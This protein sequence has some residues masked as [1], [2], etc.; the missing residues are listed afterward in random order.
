MIDFI[1]NIFGKSNSQQVQYWYDNRGNLI[2]PKSGKKLF[3]VGEEEFKTNFSQILELG[4]GASPWVYIVVDRIAELCASV[5]LVLVNQEGELIN[6]RQKSMGRVN[7]LQSLINEPQELFNCWSFKAITYRCITQYLLTGNGFIVGFPFTNESPIRYNNLIP[8]LSDETTPNQTSEAKIRDW[9]VDYFSKSY[10]APDADVMHMVRPNPT[11]DDNIGH[12]PLESLVNIWKA[13][14]YLNANEHQIH[15]NKGVNGILSTKGERPILNDERR[16]ID[17]ILNEE[18][19]SRERVAKFQY[20]PREMTYVDVS[21]SFK[22]LQADKSSDRHREII[23]AAYKYPSALLNDN[24]SLTYNNLKSLQKTAFIDAVLPVLNNY[25]NTLN[26]WLVVD[27]YGL[28]TVKIGYIE[29]DIPQLQ[30]INSDK[31]DDD[32]KRQKMIIDIN[33][34]VTSGE[35]SRQEAINTL[36]ITGFT[37]EEAQ[38]VVTNGQGRN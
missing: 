19:T 33:K 6:A 27:N 1:K 25:L 37:S 5:D 30:F 16:E 7:E 22:D 32:A 10:T 3:L 21:K 12:A 29:K 2:D 24:A 18:M 11:D 38:N 26:K 8:P 35:M 34:S 4:F 36:T 31:T 20:S 28:S 17:A 15:K 23:A 14:N 9:Q 13:N